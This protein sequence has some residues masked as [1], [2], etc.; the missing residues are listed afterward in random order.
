ML[1]AVLR[2]HHFEPNHNA[3]YKGRRIVAARNGRGRAAPVKNF[4]RYLTG[5]APMCAVTVGPEAIRDIVRQLSVI[6]RWCR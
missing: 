6:S 2:Q 4:S 3:S 1:A 5:R